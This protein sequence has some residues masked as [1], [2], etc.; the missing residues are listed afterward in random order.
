[1][2]NFKKI[3]FWENKKRVKTLNNFLTFF[4][5][6]NKNMSFTQFDDA[7]YENNEA[8]KF[9][10]EI[11]NILEKSNDIVVSTSLSS[12]LTVIEPPIAGNKQYTVNL[13]LDIFDLWRFR[14]NERPVYDRIERVIGVLKEDFIK[15]IFRTFNP[16]FWIGLILE[17]LVNLPFNLLIKIKLLNKEK[18]ESSLIVKL[19]KFIFYILFAI[20]PAFF[21]YLEFFRKIQK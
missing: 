11:N 14:V 16:F 20:I 17:Y 9:R 8:K 18:S 4:Q 2:R 1:M 3:P 10:S 5:Q 19:L 7:P 15:S 6:Y 12:N 13:I 21:A